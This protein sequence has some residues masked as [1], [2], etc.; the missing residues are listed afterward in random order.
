[1]KGT[2]DL[3]IANSGNAPYGEGE[4]AA[5]GDGEAKEEATEEAAERRRRRLRK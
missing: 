5:E 3:S 4:S 1:M 2:Y